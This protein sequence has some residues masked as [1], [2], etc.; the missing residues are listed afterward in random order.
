MAG[1]KRMSAEEKR[2]AVMGIYHKTKSVYTEKE[3][4]ALITKA[5]VNSNTAGDINQNLVD[6][7]LV[8]MQKIGGTKYYWSFPGKKDRELQVKY[9]ATLTAIESTK[10]SFNEAKAKLADVKRGREE[11]DDGNRMKKL[12][13]IDE[14]K[15]A[16]AALE[17]ELE[18]LKENDPQA[19]ADLRKEM[20][21]CTESA[22]RWTD[23]LFQCKS[24]LVKKRSMSKKE[25]G[26][27]VGISSDFDYPPEM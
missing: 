18:K 25:A 15:K 27:L 4:V 7:G 10:S 13:K 16:K 11:D 9:E 5:G 6:D 17:K 24:Y 19:L 22:N 21:F 1:A 26:Q 20:R 12:A 8:D 2:K 3:I 14:M 23:N